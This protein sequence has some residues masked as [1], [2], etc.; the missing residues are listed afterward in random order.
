[1]SE[2]GGDIRSMAW[3]RGV[4]TDMRMRI[5]IATVMLEV[6]LPSRIPSVVSVHSSPSIAS[7][8]NINNTTSNP[9]DTSRTNN[10]LNL[11]T[12]NPI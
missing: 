4:G 12:K 5:R 2:R 7:I 3:Y 10:S 9:T 1:M 11:P 8:D 6:T